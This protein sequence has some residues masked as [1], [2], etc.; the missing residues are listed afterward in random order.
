MV[1]PF[2]VIEGEGEL[3]GTD[4]YVD[5]RSMLALEKGLRTRQEA[6]EKVCLVNKGLTEYSAYLIFEPGATN[7]RLDQGKNSVKIAVGS[8]ECRTLIIGPFQD[9]SLVYA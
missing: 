9:S 4:I 5:I 8:D 7:L 1:M 3:V 6:C 2:V